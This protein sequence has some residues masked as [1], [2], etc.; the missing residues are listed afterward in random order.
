MR[1]KILTLVLLC[2][3]LIG[4]ASVSTWLSEQDTPPITAWN[5]AKKDY[6]ET[7]PEISSEM[8][9]AIEQGDVLLGMT[10]AQVVACR[11]KPQ[12]INKTTGSY[13]VHERWVMVIRWRGSYNSKGLDNSKELATKAKTYAYIYLENGIVTSWQSR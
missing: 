11:G 10:S 3:F 7:H 9:V 8:R 2:L 12:K 6:L 1:T 4:C 5:K 13:G